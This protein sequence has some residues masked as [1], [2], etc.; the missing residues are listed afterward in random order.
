M[1]E[2]K[3]AN[4]T[5][6]M[7]DY[8]VN[9]RLSLEEARKKLHANAYFRTVSEVLERYC[10]AKGSELQKKVIDILYNSSPTPVEK[11]NIRRKV[12]G[13]LSKKRISIEKEA[14]I[15]LALELKLTL[16]DAEEMI[17]RLSDEALHL[18]NPEDIVWFF[19]LTHGM[20]YLDACGLRDRIMRIYEE[21]KGSEDNTDMMTETV[22]QQ[23]DQI[24]TVKELE[25]FIASQASNLGKM[26]NT[27]YDLFNHFLE[28]LRDGGDVPV[29]GGKKIV[30]GEC[31]I[32]NILV[33]YLHRDH[34]P[35]TKRRLNDDVQREIKKNWPSETNLSKMA[36]READVTRKV[37]ILLFLACDGGEGPYGNLSEE[38]CK[39]VFN[40]KYTRLTSMLADCGFSHIDSRKPFDWM[41]LYCLAKDDTEDTDENIHD[42]LTEIFAD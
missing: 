14:V 34:I 11:D 41:V 26:H 6:I 29:A 5:R 9:E 35:N 39:D 37:L 23:L 19:A 15:Q 13:W 20:S 17:T 33:T 4:M 27:A 25:S 38:D 30:N 24:Q 22:R 12:S 1:P 21:N 18:R 36:N 2:D 3:H 31:V 10:G 7:S 40:D 32:E 8:A 28:L 42:F 16:D